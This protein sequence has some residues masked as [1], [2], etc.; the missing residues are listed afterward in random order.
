MNYE[1]ER[2]KRDT[3]GV[4]TKLV[5]GVWTTMCNRCLTEWDQV[6]HH[7]VP[8]SA[9]LELAIT[10]EM[11]QL[12]AAAGC[13]PDPAAV[14]SLLRSKRDTHAAVRLVALEFIKPLETT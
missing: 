8:G 1:C 12:R 14:R 4:T 2:C 6:F 7:S 5:G 11:M 9:L 13:S 10:E 3:N